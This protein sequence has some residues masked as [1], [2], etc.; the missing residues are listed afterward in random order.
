[1]CVNRMNTLVPFVTNHEDIVKHRNFA[2]FVK[3]KVV[4]SSFCF[5]HTY[6]FSSQSVY[7]DLLFYC[8]TL[9]LP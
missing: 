4:D 9:L 3:F 8:V 7:Q 6:D 2:L 1:M 5:M